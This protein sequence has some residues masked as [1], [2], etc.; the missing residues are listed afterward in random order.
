M[1]QSGGAL[2]NIRCRNKNLFTRFKNRRALFPPIFLKFCKQVQNSDKA[3]LATA[4]W[5]EFG[6]ANR[7][8]FQETTL[9]LHDAG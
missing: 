2:D 9:A 5:R 1:A 7:L 3:N 4:T 6:S 8:L